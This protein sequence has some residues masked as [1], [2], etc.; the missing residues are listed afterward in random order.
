VKS[1]DRDQVNMTLLRTAA[2][3]GLVLYD[4]AAEMYGGKDFAAV[5]KR[6]PWCNFLNHHHKK[7]KTLAPLPGGVS[8][9]TATPEGMAHVGFSRDRLMNNSQAALAQ[10][11]PVSWFCL[12]DQT[13][14]REL[15]STDEVAATFGC[16]SVPNNVAFVA[17]TERGGRQ[18]IFRVYVSSTD[19]PQTVHQIRTIRQDLSADPALAPWV[20]TGHLGVAVLCESPDKVSEL[21]EAVHHRAGGREAIAD[22]FRVHVGLGPSPET[23]ENALKARR[24]GKAK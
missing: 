2:L 16:D 4:F 20:A 7:S 19:V 18:T 12:A 13:N 23:V 24:K 21:R 5:F 3:H 10:R 14:P 9:V 17:A 8:Y 22:Q 11:L 1:V 6:T 15:L